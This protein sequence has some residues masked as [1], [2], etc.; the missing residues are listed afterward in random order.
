MGL[1]HMVPPGTQEEERMRKSFAVFVCSMAL[2]FAAGAA[3]AGDFD[4]LKDLNIRA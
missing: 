1:I 4:W 3:F 2:A